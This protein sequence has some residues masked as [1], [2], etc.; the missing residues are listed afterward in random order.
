MLLN[1]VENNFQPN[2]E[3]LRIQ[4]QLDT[5]SAKLVEDLHKETVDRLR[6]GY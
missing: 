4:R 6:R 2:E 1:L 3:N 5:I